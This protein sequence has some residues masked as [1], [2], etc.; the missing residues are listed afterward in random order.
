[1]LPNGQTI[2]ITKKGLLPIDNNLSKTAKMAYILPQLQNTSLLSIG[3]LCDDNCLAIFDKRNM[4]IIKNNKIILRGIRNLSDGL[5]DV[6][7]NKNLTMH[8][9][10]KSKNLLNVIMQKSKP[11]YELANF[12]HACACSPTIKTFQMAINNNLLRHGQ[13]SRN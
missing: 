8:K 9:Q 10:N 13:E 7:L 11:N 1:M 4:Y 2:K 5:W 6:I 12:L 3:Q